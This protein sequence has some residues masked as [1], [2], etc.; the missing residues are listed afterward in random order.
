MLDFFKK[1][2]TLRNQILAV[3]FIIL[4]IILLIVSTIIFRQVS[5]L[6]EENAEE[7]I[8]QTAIEVVGRYDSLFEQLNVTTTQMVTNDQVQSTLASEW[9]GEPASF[10]ER[11]TIMN[12][13]SRLQTNSDGIY[14]TELFNSELDKIYPLDGPELLEQIEPKWIDKADEARG[15]MVWIGEDRL[16]RNYFLLIR[17]ANLIDERFTN[18][19]YLLTRVNRDYFQTNPQNKHPDQLT[20]VRDQNRNIVSTNYSEFVETVSEDEPIYPLIDDEN[21]IRTQETST[22]TGF[23]I[24]MLTPTDQLTEGLPVLRSAIIFS[25]MIGLVIFFVVSYF[26]ATFITKPISRLTN[27]MRQ[28]GDGVL[29]FT[30]Q[31]VSS[32]EINE[33][34][35]TYNQLAEQTNYLIQMVYEKEL[36]KT[37]SELKALQA[38]INPHFLFNTLDSLYWS[39]EEEDQEDLA[40]MVLAMSNLFRYT[41]TRSEA[42][43]WIDL[44]SEVEHI[45]HYMTI[46]KMRFGERLYFD[47]NVDE[48]LLNVRLPKLMI[49]PLIENAVLHGI[50]EDIEKGHVWLNVRKDP[51]KHTLTV[52]VKDDGQGMTKETIQSIYESI[53]QEQS[54]KKQDS[55]ALRNVEMRIKL[56]FDPA[57]TKGLHISSEIDQG[58]TVSFTI[59][60]IKDETT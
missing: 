28:A 26:L 33:L 16:D 25:G 29:T 47:L 60:I 24:T 23:E 41:I 5:D 1:H 53:D 36:R 48:D 42:D 11:Q 55:M 38:Q 54:V 35:D 43:E 6:L 58:T 20:I 10:G 8:Q 56:Y 39:L 50:G 15:R 22:E 17:R 31:S 19:G 46:M 52:T 37:H 13:T 18:G 51:T 14:M 49:Q 40:E 12:V 2:N 44:R 9:R 30:P 4:L 27:T 7:Q 34:N 57:Q 59:P 21:Y 45:H 3:Y 32:N